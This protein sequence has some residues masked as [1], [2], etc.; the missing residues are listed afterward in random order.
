MPSQKIF[1][2]KAQAGLSALTSSGARSLLLEFIFV[3]FTPFLFQT[4]LFIIL[5]RTQRRKGFFTFFSAQKENA[6]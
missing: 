4:P 5:S 1:L 2:L 3:F 6:A